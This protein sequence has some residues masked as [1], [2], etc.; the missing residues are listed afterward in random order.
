ML[1]FIILFVYYALL[2]LIFSD[3]T[4][5]FSYFDISRFFIDMTFSSSCFLCRSFQLYCFTPALP[6]GERF[7]R[8][9]DARL[10]SYAEP[11]F[12]RSSSRIIFYLATI[13]IRWYAYILALSFFFLLLFICRLR[14]AT[15]MIV[16]YSLLLIYYTARYDCSL[17]CFAYCYATIFSFVITHILLSEVY[18]GYFL[19][20]AC[21]LP[22]IRSPYY[23]FYFHVYCSHYTY[24]IYI[25]WVIF[26]WCLFLILLLFIDMLWWCFMPLMSYASFSLQDCFSS[27]HFWYFFAPTAVEACCWYLPYAV[28]LP[29]ATPLLI[30]AGARHDADADT[31]SPRYAFEMFADICFFFFFALPYALRYHHEHHLLTLLFCRDAFAFMPSSMIDFIWGFIFYYFIYAF[32]RRECRLMVQRAREMQRASSEAQKQYILRRDTLF[33]MIFHILSY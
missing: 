13:I 30:V 31:L 8:V 5:L 32:A 7:I 2:L 26:A 4:S 11:P 24:N 25:Y 12:S 14:H 15:F 9:I 18:R 28:L 22:A 16:A 33:I 19:G 29:L 23:A 20:F 10:S 1:P 3:A 21:R 27:R 6:A 17:Y